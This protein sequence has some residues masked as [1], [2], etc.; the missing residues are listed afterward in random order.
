MSKSARKINKKEIREENEMVNFLKMIIIVTVV[1]GL[2]YLLTVFI[3][4]EDEEPTTDNNAKETIQY[5][6]IL[7]G[8]IFSKSGNYYVLVE[9]AGDKNTQVYEAYLNVYSEK[10][11]S[12]RV[13][14]S[15]L[16]DILNS[17]YISEQ[18]NLS[19]KL[20]ELKFSSTIL[21]EIENGKIKKSY[22]SDTEIRNVVKELAKEVTAK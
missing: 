17:K 19:N 4:K 14:I 10:E 8:N 6:E 5:D 1:F 3:N 22:E 11:D 20:S 15:K 7:I 9:A 18:T 13:Y 21:L 12:K 2:F 16:N